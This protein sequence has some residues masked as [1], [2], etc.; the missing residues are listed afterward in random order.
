MHFLVRISNELEHH[1]SATAAE[2]AGKATF[3]RTLEREIFWEGEKKRKLL[4]TQ[5]FEP[6]ES[7]CLRGDW[8]EGRRAAIFDGLVSALTVFEAP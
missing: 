7:P 4:I 1:I 5:S 3:G 2:P 8:R 6:G